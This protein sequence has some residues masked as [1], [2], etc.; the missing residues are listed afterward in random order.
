MPAPVAMIP[1]SFTSVFSAPG[2]LSVEPGIGK[3]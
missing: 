3:L 1:A 2:T